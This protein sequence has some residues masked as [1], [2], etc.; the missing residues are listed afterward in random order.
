MGIPIG[1]LPQRWWPK[2][3]I[4]GAREIV[5]SSM[6]EGRREVWIKDHE[7]YSEVWA[8]FGHP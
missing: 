3:P 7:G 8:F 5:I 4:P 6:K 1:Y 2:K